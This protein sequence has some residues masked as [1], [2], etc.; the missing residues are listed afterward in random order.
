[1]AIVNASLIPKPK[2]PVKTK[3]NSKNP[4]NAD[5]VAAMIRNLLES[6]SKAS[7]E[8]KHYSNVTNGKPPT[9]KTMAPKAK[10]LSKTMHSSQETKKLSLIHI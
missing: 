9:F 6:P 3:G 1:M 5:S 2:R 4:P 10:N 8:P 7:Q